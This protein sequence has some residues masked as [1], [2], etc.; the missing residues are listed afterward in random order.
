MTLLDSAASAHFYHEF[1]ERNPQPL[2]I[3]DS[4][5]LRFVAVNDAAMVAYGYSRDEFLAMTLTEVCLAEDA[6][7]LSEYL[8]A[9]ASSA[10]DDSP[11]VAIPTAWRHRKKDGS[12]IE[13]EVSAHELDWNGVPARLVTLRDVTQM[14]RMQ[15]A[16]Q[17]LAAHTGVPF[18]LAA[19]SPS[20]SSPSTSSLLGPTSS[21]PFA[22]S[23][24]AI[25]KAASG[26]EQADWPSLLFTLD[27]G[28]DFFGVL[29]Q[30]LA[31]VL[32]VA[33]ALVTLRTA[34]G[35]LRTLGFWANG[36]L[37][38]PIEYSMEETPCGEVFNHSAIVYYP[39]NAQQ[40]FPK[41]Q[42]IKDLEAVSCYG[43]PIVG[44]DGAACGHLCVLHTKPLR[45]RQ[46]LEAIFQ[47]FVVRATL[48]I[49]RRQA[50]HALRQS[51]SSLRAA[52]QQSRAVFDSA[53]II[54]FVVDRA[55]VLTMVAGKALQT[56]GISA[57][58]TIGRTIWEA[59][60]D[61]P[62]VLDNV[63]R[64]M[65]GESFVSMVKIGEFRF[66]TSYAPNV[67]T[68]GEIIG[69]IGVATD[70]TEQE[71]AKTALVE[72]ERKYRGIFENA[73]EGIYQTTLDGHII[74]AN[75]M[76]AQILGYG[77]P[78][79]L[80]SSVTQ[81]AQH[82]Y[83]DP[84]RRDEFARLMN[85]DGAVSRFESW[86]RRANGEIACVSENARILRDADG[87]TVGYEGT[88]IEVTDRKNAEAA[89][90][91]SENRL[92]DIVEHSSNLFYSHTPDHI[93]TYVSPQARHFFDC[94][95]EEALVEWTHFTTDHPLNVI[96]MEL[97]QRAIDSGERQK[98]FRLELQTQLGRRLWVEVNEAPVL[99]GGRTVAIVGALADITER[100]VIEQKLQHQAFHDALTGLPN[101]TL[102]M[103]RLQHVLERSRRDDH[104]H[105]E[106][107]AILF[108]DLDRFK[109]VNDSL[110]HEVGDQL[111]QAVARRLTECLRSGDTAA[112]LGGDEFVILLENILAVDD[113]TRIADR[114]A[115]EL[116]APFFLNGH[117]IF[118]STS[119]GIKTTRPETLEQAV[120]S[121]PADWLEIGQ[122]EE[123]A[124]A[125]S[126]SS[127]TR[128]PAAVA[129]SAAVA[130]D[131][132][133]RDAD[134]A[135]YRAKS[136][137]RSRYE[138]FDP[139]MNARALERL[140][141]ETDLRQ[142][143]RREQLCL[144]YQPIVRTQ[145][146]SLVGFEALLRWQH[147][148]LGLLR[149]E[150]FLSLAEE[151]GLIWEM[152]K[153]VMEEACRQ[154]RIW[155]E[156]VPTTLARQNK[157]DYGVPLQ[158]NLNLSARQF[159]QIDLVP[160]LSQ[161]LERTTLNPGGITLEITESVVM[162]EA[163]KTVDTLRNLKALGV[164]LAIDD[165]G[166]GYSS[167]SY[168]RRFPVDTL[169]IDRSFIHNLGAQSEETEIVRAILSLART[170]RLKVV[171]EGVETEEQLAQLQALGCDLVQGY[172]FSRPLSAEDA[173][174]LLMHSNATF[175]G[176]DEQT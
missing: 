113:A 103:S 38:A 159:R 55:G 105:N 47:I 17:S 106:Q 34:K 88:V 160:Q 125:I 61:A 112:R 97:T 46:K 41:N 158:I 53:P 132:H 176:F 170:L 161:V 74:T 64:A 149:P 115:Q 165:F 36:K 111:L 9:L 137:G 71:Q 50:E 162:D 116:R 121:L 24:P 167:L 114:I 144:H 96:G 60:R 21:S 174:A 157:A 98:P 75:L 2:W 26:V 23:S 43:A 83:V 92:R 175:A 14:R 166:T 48:E 10:A 153:W 141:L 145:N 32:D 66:H 151:A 99:R 37:Q 109:V 91:A 80:I 155:Q 133:L 138:I 140:R 3:Y 169:K 129:V 81:I 65:N 4:K 89:L 6:A 130:A 107:N 59:Y 148:R 62:E 120:A 87:A 78:T 117:E 110:G 16:L 154:V 128:W 25:E 73:V 69:V 108:L 49:N 168:L 124:E 54:A 52:E 13:V 123:V 104:R 63:R 57:E 90:R 15:H 147:P 19:P 29:T 58:E 93:L 42:F 156:F 142:A 68:S 127:S 131:A 82:F 77:S 20:T 86:V 44:Q 136:K 163:E 118:V 12:I 8:A 173:S 18:P 84:N 126:G 139:E 150:A 22:P 7:R 33:Y 70:V 31:L 5:S 171:A 45:D 100:T 51:E 152:G 35:T 1:F 95:P 56:L 11:S 172:L 28:D 134:V 72:T 143:V 40:A 79:E 164:S 27:A 39:D 67:D 119:I 102:F 30:N 101:R 94:E 122:A 85:Q 76:M 135:M 146:G